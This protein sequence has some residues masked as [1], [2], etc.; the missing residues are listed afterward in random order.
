MEKSEVRALIKGYIATLPPQLK[1]AE[2]REIIARILANPA[3]RKAQSVFCYISRDNE[4][5]SYPLLEAALI[6]GKI[7]A[8]PFVTQRGLMEARQICD[9]SQLQPDRYG[10]LAPPGAGIL[11]KADDIDLAIVP[12]LAFDKKSL[13]RLG[14]GG[15]YYDRYLAGSAAFR[16]AP[17]RAC[18]IVED[19]IPGEPYDLSMDM[20]ITPDTVYTKR[21]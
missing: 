13:L 10:I 2:D 15:G 17:A 11:V 19:L 8:A 20:L 1:A 21:Q 7:L 9:L 5:N 14:Q 3:W 12:G 16:L 18:Q 4:I 6:E